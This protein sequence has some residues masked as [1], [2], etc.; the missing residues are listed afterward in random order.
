MLRK[1][2]G[3]NRLMKVLLGPNRMLQMLMG[4]KRMMRLILGP[5]SE[6]ITGYWK[7]IQN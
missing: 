7:K 3:S 5:S 1:L 6:G 2:L 4:L